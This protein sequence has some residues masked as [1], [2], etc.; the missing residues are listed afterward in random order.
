MVRV[1]TSGG[2]I[3]G[4]LLVPP[5]LR[6]LD[7]VSTVSQKYLTI[8]E[9]KLIEGN[10]EFAAGPLALSKSSVLF[11]M[12]SSPPQSRPASMGDRFGQ[13]CF[14]MRVAAYDLTGFIHFPLG[15]TP[16]KRLD[17]DHHGFLALTTVLVTS[18]DSEL[19]VPFLA[20]NR[21]HII[22]AQHIEQTQ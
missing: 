22:G 11:L 5:R 13:A 16:M 1:Y 4:S 7:Y 18:P 15:G 6:T 20:V 17:Q 10:W 21:A 14:R 12:E 19:T 2:T 9:P 3:E 8:H